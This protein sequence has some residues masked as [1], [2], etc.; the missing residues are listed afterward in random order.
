[1]YIHEKLQLVLVVYVDDFKMAGPQKNLA[2]GW[3]MLHTRLKIEPETGLDMY[4]GCNQSKGNVTLVEQFLRSCVDRYLE[5]AGDVK[6]N[7]VVT[8][9]MHEETKNHVS[10]KPAKEGPSVVCNW[11]NNLVPT[12]GSA[13]APDQRGGTPE[14][15][16]KEPVRGHLAPHAA[17]VLMKL[18][19]G[20]RIARFDLLRQVNR[21]AR[22]VHRWTDSDDRGLRHLMCYV[23]RTKHWRMVGWV[24]DPMDDVR[25]AEDN[26]E[27]FFKAA[28]HQD[29]PVREVYKE[30]VIG[31]STRTSSSR[32][33]RNSEEFLTTAEFERHD[34]RIAK[35]RDRRWGRVFT[36]GV[37][38]TPKVDPHGRGLRAD[39]QKNW[40][41]GLAYQN[42]NLAYA[43]RRDESAHQHNLLRWMICGS[44]PSDI[45]DAC[46]GAVNSL[47]C[48]SFIMR[49][50][51][52]LI[53]EKRAADHSYTTCFRPD[54]TELK[55]LCR[56]I[57]GG[58]LVV[59]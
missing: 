41:L 24:G 40:D 16:T 28:F 30:F 50:L 29:T 7:K 14:L 57:E 11:C 32:R 13:T 1:M 31:E 43:M 3:S 23:H 49:R 38:R 59:Y 36:L 9:E 35:F 52:P 33:W 42:K 18:L 12:D 10:R 39:Y 47:M 4:L 2:Q 20:A 22:N 54:K 48:V 56:E 21:L 45:S 58:F 44:T 27:R 5:V 17:S 6:L 19:Y 37:I 25:L 46:I 34:R 55:D 15:A 51:Q 8:P 26:E 53:G